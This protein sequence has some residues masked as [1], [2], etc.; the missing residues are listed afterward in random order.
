MTERELMKQA[1]NTYFLPEL[2]NLGF[3]GDFPN[4]YRESKN[5][6]D[7]LC[8]VFDQWGGS[9]ALEAS[10]ALKGDG[11]NNLLPG[12]C[13]QPLSE[14]SVFKTRVRKR[15]PAD[16][17]WIYF[18]D[19]VRF[20]SEKGDTIYSLTQKQKQALLKNIPADK[21]TVEEEVGDGIYC[22]SAL[23]AVRLLKIAEKWWNK[24]SA[25]LPEEE[26]EDDAQQMSE[27]QKRWGFFKLIQ[28]GK[29]KKR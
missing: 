3:E 5:K 16:G 21:I 26:S 22:R 25:M 15:I 11:E 19:L 29:S 17:E 1:M 2:K 12:K 9:F 13:L 4:Y 18:C 6:V 7:L 10:Y 24:N 20:K 28:G 27:P 23:T 8:V 14:L